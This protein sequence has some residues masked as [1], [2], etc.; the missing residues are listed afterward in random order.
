MLELGFDALE[1]AFNIIKQESMFNIFNSITNAIEEFNPEHAS[2]YSQGQCAIVIE[3]VFSRLYRYLRFKSTTS[4]KFTRHFNVDMGYKY[5]TSESIF[6]SQN[7]EWNKAY[8]VQEDQ[9]PYLRYLLKLRELMDSGVIGF[10]DGE[11]AVLGQF[12][13]IL[14]KKA[15]K[16]VFDENY[17]WNLCPLCTRGR[18]E[19][20]VNPREEGSIQKTGLT[21]RNTLMG[22]IA[23]RDLEL[24]EASRTIV[25]NFNLQQYMHMDVDDI[26]VEDNFP[27]RHGSVVQQNGKPFS[28][29]IVVPDDGSSI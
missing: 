22:M 26:V 21:M 6:G 24:Q 18:D 13:D 15:R 4:E 23:T 2:S 9:V 29:Q 3:R 1:D 19:S 10:S 25:V 11:K 5:L 27:Y 20:K 8:Y 7:N 14:M 12:I 16:H 17:D 28:L